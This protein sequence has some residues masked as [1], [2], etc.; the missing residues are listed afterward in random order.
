MSRNK[1]TV[2]E[3]RIG[4]SVKIVIILLALLT[5]LKRVR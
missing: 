4:D 2:C 5:F 3:T 1:R